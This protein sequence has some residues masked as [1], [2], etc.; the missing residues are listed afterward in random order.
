MAEEERV[1][2]DK[3]FAAARTATESK[4]IEDCEEFLTEWFIANLSELE[5]RSLR[6]RVRDSVVRYWDLRQT[7]A[8]VMLQ[9]SA[10][11]VRHFDE[12]MDRFVK[13]GRFRLHPWVLQGFA[14]MSLEGVHASCLAYWLWMPRAADG[15]EQA[16][17]GDD[18][19][20]FVTTA[21]AMAV[22][23]IGMRVEREV[24]Q[25]TRPRRTATEPPSDR[26]PG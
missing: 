12:V 19:R 2:W 20:Q 5:A 21:I 16:R 23:M 24:P 6:D 1:D 3:F 4:A 9:H 26:T 10:E 18:V 17:L 13:S 7:A 15:R 14:A 22:R 25:R 11:H 8:A